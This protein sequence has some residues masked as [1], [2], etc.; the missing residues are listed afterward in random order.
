MNVGDFKWFQFG[1]AWIYGCVSFYEPQS[2]YTELVA[3]GRLYLVK[4]YNLFDEIPQFDG[5][6]LYRL[7]KLVESVMKG[8]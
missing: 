2:D 7:E 3:D 8:N 1:C 5:L 6:E 4:R